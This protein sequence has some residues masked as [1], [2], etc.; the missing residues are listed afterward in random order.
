MIGTVIGHYRIVD[1]LGEGGM[2]E[3][4]LVDDLKL[5]R[6][7]ALKLIKPELTRDP[8]RRE[9]FLQEATL[10]ASVDHPHITA[11]YDIDEADGRTYIAME[12]VEGRPLRDLLKAGPLPLR[13]AIDLALQIADALAKVHERGVVHRDLEPEHILVA[14]DGYAK[15]I[16]FG[17][18]KLVD[19]LP[20]TSDADTMSDPHVQTA[21]GLVLGTMGY[22]SP[23]QVRGETVDARSDIFSFGALLYEMVSGVAPFRRTSAA[24]TISAVLKEPP[25][26]VRIDDALV[27]PELQ[28]VLR[29]CLVKDAAGRYQSLRDVAVDL[30]EIRASLTSGEVA[31][32]RTT[33]AAPPAPTPRRGRTRLLV[34]AIAVALVMGAAIWLW[35]RR[36]A[37]P[38]AVA[39]DE[40]GRPSVAIMTFDVITGGSDVAWLNKGLPSMLV[41]GLAQTPDL[42]VVGPERLRDAARQLGASSV[43]ALDASR[44]A[45]IVRRAGARYVVSGNI[46]QA[47]GDIRID[48]RVED[49]TTGAVRWADSVRGADAM[50]LADELSARIRRGLN[51]PPTAVQRVADVTSESVEAYRAYTAG[52]DASQNLRIDDAVRLF[53]EAARLDPGFA[54]AHVGLARLARAAGRESERRASLAEA[55]RHLDRLVERDQWLVQTELAIADEQ[56]DEVNRVLARLIERYPDTEQAYL[57]SASGHR[58]FGPQPDSPTALALLERGVRALPYS[59]AIQ[60]AYG[61]ALLEN[62]RMAEAVDA[63]TRYV[64]LRPAEPNAI[65]GLGEGQLVAGDLEA[66]LI[67]F[68]RAFEGG[69]VPAQRMRGWTLAVMGRMDEALTDVVAVE[70]AVTARFQHIARHPADDAGEDR[71]R[72]RGAPAGRGVA[73]SFRS[74]E[75]RPV[76]HVALRGVVVARERRVRRRQRT[77]R[78]VDTGP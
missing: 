62:G 76:D 59:A 78:R 15:I 70:G 10:A 47:G 4:Y 49:L 6:R 20:A 34:A 50:A 3:V 36:D 19:R 57:T 22:M 71:T 66:A 69:H 53:K 60:N 42:E 28:R 72:P 40:P 21:D 5:H 25:A 43:E 74:G 38:A 51:V 18:A 44:T 9:R 48:A 14:S 29:T 55:V 8:Q 54:L 58:F 45:E 46:M 33:G 68:T 31:G 61:Y 23:E 52:V 26:A 63:F 41:T 37:T 24:E 27:E 11:I 13:R 67:S 77:A 7:A 73:T 32:T 64:Q 75:S 17:I 56:W 39:T 12:Y 2:G 35:T 30:R 1:R 65:D 16:D